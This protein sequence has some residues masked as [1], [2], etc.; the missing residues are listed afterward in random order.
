MFVPLF[1]LIVIMSGLALDAGSLYNRKAEVSGL[2]KAAALAAAQE[3]NGTTEGIAAAQLK[4]KEA[5][6]RF[7]YQ[8]GLSVTWD[9]AAIRF[10]TGPS[11]SGEW[12]LG[13]DVADASNYYFVKVDTAAMT[14]VGEVKP[15]FMP[16]FSSSL[17]TVQISDTAVAG[18]ASIN[19]TPIAICA[20]SEDPATPRTNTGLTDNELVEYGF[21]RGVNYDLM[22]LNPKGTTPARYLVNPVSAPGASASSFNTSIIG[23]FACTGTMWVP[24]LRGG[25]IHVTELGS[26]S[27]LLSVFKQLNSRLDDY[28]GGLCSPTSAPPDS[29]VKQYPY[30]TTGGAPWM[31]P[32]TGTRAATSTTERG[33]L[34]TVADIPPPGSII[35][36]LTAGSYGPVWSFAKAVKFSSYKAGV[37]EPSNGYATFSTGD[38][39]K[40]YKA[41]MGVSTSGYPTGAQS[42]PYD[43]VGSTNPNTIATP[44]VTRKDFSTQYRRVLNIPLL[45]CETVPTGSN[46]PA[47]VK[48]IGKFFMTVQATEDKLVAEFAGMTYENALIG[49]VELYP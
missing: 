32:A 11:R 1:I 31:S 22:Q 10:S 20:M 16:I 43:P 14:L 37:P 23:P 48:G 33:K 4:A 42:T 7:T 28:T 2:A 44:S 49:P 46:V 47:T 12:A 26:T 36:G 18:R 25:S 6:E 40:L 39:A 5:A 35:S 17:N 8:Y 29:N 38:W 24:R 15:V 3:L 13:S 19:V 9:S 30:D 27:P 21:R 41:G 34:E 45:S